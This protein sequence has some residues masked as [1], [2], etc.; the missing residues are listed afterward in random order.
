MKSGFEFSDK[1]FRLQ[2]YKLE[3]S[4]YDIMREMDCV[5]KPVYKSNSNDY[6]WYVFPRMEPITVIFVKTYRR[7]T[8]YI[9]LVKDILSFSHKNNIGYFDWKLDNIMCI[10]K[11]RR[12]RSESS[13][14]ASEITDLFKLFD[15]EFIDLTHP[16]QPIPCTHVYNGNNYINDKLSIDSLKILDNSIALKDIYMVMSSI[17]CSEYIKMIKQDLTTRKL[18]RLLKDKMGLKITIN[19]FDDTT[20]QS[21]LEEIQNMLDN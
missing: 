15:I 1:I 18:I 16:I 7:I 20:T 14:L 11:I 17:N 8:E 2:F 19:K 9:K 21:I 12:S 10:Q 6:T 13:V 3:N 4:S 5:I